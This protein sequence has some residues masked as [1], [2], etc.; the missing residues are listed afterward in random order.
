[1]RKY[2]IIAK[3]DKIKFVKYRTN[4]PQKTIDFIK[5]KFGDVL[6][7]N[8]YFKTGLNKGLQFGS[9]GKKKGLVIN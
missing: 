1:M 7:A 9:Y 5:K 8:I 6:Y 2:T 3:V 4:H